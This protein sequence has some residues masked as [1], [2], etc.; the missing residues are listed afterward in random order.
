MGKWEAVTEIPPTGRGNK[1]IELQPGEKR[2]IATLH[3]YSA[4]N[5][6]ASFR[7][8]GKTDYHAVTRKIDGVVYIYIWRDPIEETA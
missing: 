8:Q 3:V 6:L 5:Y 7:K 1:A 2:R 4:G